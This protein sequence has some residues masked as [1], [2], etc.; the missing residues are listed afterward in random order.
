MKSP[1]FH[2]CPEYRYQLEKK[3]QQEKE[4]LHKQQQ[5]VTDTAKTLSWSKI[6]QNQKQE[7][8]H[9][10]SNV[11]NN[12][13]ATHQLITNNTTDIKTQIT[14]QV[15][16]LKTQIREII[17]EEVK[18]AVTE[19]LEELKTQIFQALG[20]LVRSE[21]VGAINAEESNMLQLLKTL[22]SRTTSQPRS[23][24]TTLPIHRPT[25]SKPGKTNTNH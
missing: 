11:Q 12:Q 14:E 5:S 8:Q 13:Q 15:G 7:T 2:S 19:L 6:V 9:V 17:R 18:K 20:E 23:G 3:R 4:A 10:I 16:D 21:V 1:Y 22:K 24:M 25:T